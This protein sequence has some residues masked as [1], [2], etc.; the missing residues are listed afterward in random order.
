MVKIFA[1]DTITVGLK[2]DGTILYAGLDKLIEE[3]Q[4]KIN[5]TEQASKETKKSETNNAKKFELKVKNYNS[6]DWKDITDVS[7][8][9]GHIIGLKNDGT[10]VSAGDN[11]YGRC[12]VAGWKDISAVRHS[13][14]MKS[15][16]LFVHLSQI[17]Q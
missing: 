11:T 10:V 4:A 1:S 2:N 12:D 8:S 15:E 6:S 13:R 9:N 17:I 16:Q 3:E 14:K 5:K 7:V